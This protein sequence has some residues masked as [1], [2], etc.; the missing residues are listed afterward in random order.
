MADRPT[1]VSAIAG[2]L[3]ALGVAGIIQPFISKGSNSPH[4]AESFWI[5][6]LSAVAVLSGFYLLK[7]RGWARWLS[8]AWIGAHLGISFLNSF[9]EVAV[10]AVF[11]VLIA[12]LLFR[13]DANEWFRNQC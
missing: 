9:Q 13:R 10:H 2:L 3:I 8:L 4:S 7:R 5:L 6:A 1:S 12:Y 11:F